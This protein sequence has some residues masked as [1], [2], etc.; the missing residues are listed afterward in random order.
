MNGDMAQRSIKSSMSR[1]VEDKLPRTISRVT[2]ST[3]G[4]AVRSSGRRA[5]AIGT[6]QDE[7]V[8]AIDAGPE[9]GCHETR[10]VVLVD[11]GWS[12]DDHA[13]EESGARVDGN[14]SNASPAEV[15]ATLCDGSLARI[16]RRSALRQRRA[17][18]QQADGGDAEVDQL[19]LGARQVVR[20]QA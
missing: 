20:V 10:G 16:G 1:I 14:R 11:D 3:T 5:S 2:G 13:R 15:H 7:V 19:D 8:G 6:L 9:P 4:A 12:F 18:G 17:L